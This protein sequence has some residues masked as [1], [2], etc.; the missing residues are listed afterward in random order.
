MR[1]LDGSFHEIFPFERSPLE[2]RFQIRVKGKKL[3]R[4]LWIEQRVA[5]NA[6]NEWSRLSPLVV[7]LTYN[8]SAAT[9]PQ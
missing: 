6:E 8:V 5:G 1:R 3:G 4:I 2:Q 9:T 7:V